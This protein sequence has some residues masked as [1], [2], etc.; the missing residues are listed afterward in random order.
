MNINCDELTILRIAKYYYLD[1]LSQK[2]IAEKENFHRSQISRILKMARELGYVKIEI[3]LPSGNNT[4]QLGKQLEL[5][6]GLKQVWVAPALSKQEEPL[7]ALGF[8]AARQLEKILP[9][10]KNIGIG[11]GTTLYKTASCLKYQSTEEPLEFFSLVGYTGVNDI[12]L[13]SNV[14]LESFARHF[15]GK[16]HFNNFPSYRRKDLM[17]PLDMSR[18]NDL[19]DS[20]KKLDTAVISIGGPLGISN[21]HFEE[22]PVE[23]HNLQ[24]KLANPHGDLVGTVFFDNNEFLELPD[25][26]ISPSISIPTLQKIPNIICIAAGSEKV[27]SIISAARQKYI[28]ML[29]TDEATAKSLLKNA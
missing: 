28:N 24:E 21:P 17:S 15:D 10:C 12:A 8:F 5:K 22:Y 11:A 4:E 1:G 16:C 2:Q 26:Y 23:I 27:Y 3:A 9:Y 6:L 14:L 13:Q 29:I 20:Y 7:E 19:M 18:Y 25:Y